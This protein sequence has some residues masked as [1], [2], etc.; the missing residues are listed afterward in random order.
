MNAV[1]V[2]LVLLPALASADIAARQQTVASTRGILSSTAITVPRGHVEA[3]LQ[4]PLSLPGVILGVN[5][6]VTRTTELWID[7]GTSL[8]DG[9]ADPERTFGIGVKQVIVRGAKAAVALTGA[10]RRVSTRILES[11]GYQSLGGVG[12]LCVDDR[13]IVELSAAYQYLFNYRQGSPDGNYSYGAHLVS[14]GA[15]V[16]S[17]AVRGLIEVISIKED[18]AVALG[19]RWAAGGFALDAAVV[20][21]VDGGRSAPLPWVAVTGRM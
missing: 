20:L 15:S 19:A 3:T 13:C 6:G 12:T 1:T 7:G 16:G 14:L 8:F 5:V 10:L 9:D 4:L 17:P 18:R 21:T 2:V 11:K